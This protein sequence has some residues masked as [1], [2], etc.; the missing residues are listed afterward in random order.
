GTER[1]LDIQKDHVELIK[2][3]IVRLKSNG[4][5]I[6]ST[7]FRKFKLDMGSLTDLQIEDITE[8]TI[9]VD[10]ERNKKIHYCWNIK[11]KNNER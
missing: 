5:L 9:P 3:C 11:R 2:K 10:F 8:E 6:F 1:T 4:I 7:N